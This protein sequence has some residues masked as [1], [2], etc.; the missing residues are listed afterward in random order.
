MMPPDFWAVMQ[1][2]RQAWSSAVAAQRSCATGQPHP[3]FHSHPT[4][5]GIPAQSADQGGPQDSLC[6]WS[7]GSG[8]HHTASTNFAEDLHTDLTPVCKWIWALMRICCFV[9][10]H[11]LHEICC[12]KGAETIMWQVSHRLYTSVW[13]A[14]AARRIHSSKFRAGIASILIV[15]DVAAR[16]IDLPFLDNVINYDFPAK[17]KLFIHRAG[18]AARAGGMP[19]WHA[20]QMCCACTHHTSVQSG[21]MQILRKCYA[22]NRAI[23]HGILPLH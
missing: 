13:H 3:Y 12:L 8:C 7:D 23:G 19:A 15:T 1:A 18:R 14:Q 2:G 10:P 22:G 5:C 21:G 9:R 20:S 17:P 6:L 16:G 11:C 4:P